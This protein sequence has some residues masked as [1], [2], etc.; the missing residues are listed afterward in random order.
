MTEPLS[1]VLLVN[2]PRGW[3]SHDIV[4]K[5]R[6][7]LG[8]KK[9][10]HTGT[11]DP[12]AEG[13]LVVCLGRATKIAR[14]LTACTKTYH[15]RCRLGME[16][17]TYDAEGLEPDGSAS[18]VSHLSRHDIEAELDKFRGSIDQTVPPF[19]A[20]RVD[21]ERLYTKARRGDK[22]DLPVR[23]VH[24]GKLEL[25]E[26]A[27]PF[28]EI[29][30]A[31]SAGTYIRSLAH[32][33]GRALGCGAYLESLTRTALGDMTI[34]QALT[35]EEIARLHQTGELR[36]RLLSTHDV[37]SLP[38]VVVTDDFADRIATG[39]SLG[40]KDVI[41]IHGE[42]SKLDEIMLKNRNGEVVAIG[43]ALFGSPSFRIDGAADLIKY[44][45]VL[46]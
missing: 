16:S 37:L 44:G 30:I 20:V 3:T 32:D 46:N 43:R 9:A 22:I 10:G 5:L 13:L 6:G 4:A 31:C 25:T 27:L 41:D 33:L 19:S 26:V 40:T 39:R 2:K 17:S 12:L 21:G 24:I 38:A 8:Q 29:E 1:G 42:F 7:M 15:A 23:R 35:L 14:L 28:I 45:R 18:D 34:A 36:D 11:L